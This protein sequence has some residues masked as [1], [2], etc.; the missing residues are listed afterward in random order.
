VKS[1]SALKAAIAVLVAALGFERAQPSNGTIL[2]TTRSRRAPLASR[3]GRRASLVRLAPSR[4][5]RT[6]RSA[7]SLSAKRTPAKYAPKANTIRPRITVPN[8]PCNGRGDF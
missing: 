3:R 7:Y 6:M 8:P 1:D 4:R 2:L 5:V